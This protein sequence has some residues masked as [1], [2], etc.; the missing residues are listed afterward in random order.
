M[1]NK[2]I[3]T[4]SL[5]ISSIM[6]FVVI[7]ASIPQNNTISLTSNPLH[8]VITTQLDDPPSH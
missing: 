1:K 6:L 5:G 7:S 4:L 2:F 3:K 8:T